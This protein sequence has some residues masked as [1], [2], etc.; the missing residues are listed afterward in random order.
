LIILAGTGLPLNVVASLGVAAAVTVLIISF[1]VSAS[2]LRNKA[3][4]MV[5][6][7]RKAEFSSLDHSGR[8]SVRF[9]TPAA[10]RRHVN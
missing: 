9:L 8:L 3:E 5:K 10:Y 2:G 1:L 4:K 7:Q 6:K